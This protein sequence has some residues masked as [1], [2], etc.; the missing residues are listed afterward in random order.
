[1]LEKAW[2][3]EVGQTF[4]S[5]GGYARKHTDIFNA[6]KYL[7][8]KSGQSIEVS[9]SKS[10]H[11]DFTVLLPPYGFF[12]E[13]KVARSNLPLSEISDEQRAWLSTF[14]PSSWIWLGIGRGNP[15]WAEPREPRRAYLVEW[16]YWL[17]MEDVLIQH[18]LGGVAYT[19]H[20]VAHRSVLSAGSLLR[21]YR[22]QWSSGRWS[23]PNGHPLWSHL[24]THSFVDKYQQEETE[25]A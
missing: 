7:A 21:A 24:L 10:G 2:Y 14:V 11:P 22:L 17:H 18:G 9:Q 13:V 20:Q 19:P 1:M 6:V 23:I 4:K 16:N 12:V 3:P 8:Q 5:I 25:D 15:N